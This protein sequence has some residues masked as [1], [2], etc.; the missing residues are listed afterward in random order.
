MKMLILG[1]VTLF[2]A[3]VLALLA[4]DDPGYVLIAVGEWTVETTLALAAVAIVLSFSILYYGIRIVRRVLAVPGGMRQWK[5]QRRE[6]KAMKSLTRGLIDLAEGHWAAAEKNVMKYVQDGNKRLRD[7]VTISDEASLLNYL[8][9]A[10]AAQAQG[11]DQR[12]DYYLKLAYEKHPSADIAIGLTQAELQLQQNQL[13]Q[14]LATLRHLQQLS[15][16]HAQ[17]LQALAKLY[18][19]LGDWEHLLEI[20]PLLRKYKA[21]PAD[22]I[23]NISQQSYLMLLKAAGTFSEISDVWGRIPESFREN[24]NVLLAYVTCLLKM[25]ESNV[26]E[27]LLRHAR[28]ILTHNQRPIR[29]S[30]HYLRGLAHRRL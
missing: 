12:R 7:E 27:P 26:A 18:E 1:L 16:K 8:S 4:V 24:V 25:G 20:V 13:E 10:R 5:E 9:A 11:A 21:M 2:V 28:M 3:V 23:T 29:G 30:F 15:P 17:V 22:S 19:R 6:H 14:A